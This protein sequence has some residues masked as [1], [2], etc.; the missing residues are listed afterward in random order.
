MAS[1]TTLLPQPF[2][3]IGDMYMFAVHASDAGQSVPGRLTPVRRVITFCFFF[4]LP[5]DAD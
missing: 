1:D 2:C 3:L 5:P 4:L